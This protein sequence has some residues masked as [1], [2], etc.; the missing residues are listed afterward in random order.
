MAARKLVGLIL[1]PPGSA[2]L[3]L[4]GLTMMLLGSVAVAGF[5]AG[6]PAMHP[7]RTVRCGS[8]YMMAGDDVNF[9]TPRVIVSEGCF[10][11]RN[12]TI[13]PLS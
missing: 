9:S 1:A 12:S 7:T 6:R 3:P 8:A 5:Q 11:S 10:A 13:S 2:A 4:F